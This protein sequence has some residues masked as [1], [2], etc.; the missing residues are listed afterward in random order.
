MWKIGNY[1]LICIISDFD[2]K[3][4]EL[5]EIKVFIIQKRLEVIKHGMK[6]FTFIRLLTGLNYNIQKGF[7][8]NIN[9]AIKVHMII[10]FIVNKAE[11][12]IFLNDSNSAKANC[13]TYLQSQKS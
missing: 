9:E 7:A 12:L 8:D 10:A 1:I 5:H 13:S 4:A 11:L 3:D 6:C 2:F